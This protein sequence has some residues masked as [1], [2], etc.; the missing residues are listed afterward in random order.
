M[1]THFGFIL[2][3]LKQGKQKQK[4]TIELNQTKSFSTEKET[5]N[6]LKR[7]PAEWE[8]IFANGM[9]DKGLISIIYKEVR[10][11]NIKKTQKW[12]EDLNTYFSFFFLF[13]F[14]LSFCYFFGPLPRHMEGP[15]LG[16]ELEL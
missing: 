10:Q 2:H 3:F 7:P 4:Q 13:F 14:C 9:T 11:F 16:V 5:V 6:K 8:K 15:R 1:G 12:V